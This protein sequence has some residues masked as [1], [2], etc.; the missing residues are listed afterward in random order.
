MHNRRVQSDCFQRLDQFFGAKLHARRGVRGDDDGNG[1][2]MKK[3][4][5]KK[6]EGNGSKKI[7]HAV[8]KII[9]QPAANANAKN[10]SRMKSFAI[11]RDE[12]RMAQRV[13]SAYSTRLIRIAMYDL[14]GN[15][16]LRPSLS[17]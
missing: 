2:R 12:T 10:A 5:G 13:I 1:F 17:A 11:A 8:A 15:G 4:S 14:P 6:R 9:L 3:T 16:T 7:F